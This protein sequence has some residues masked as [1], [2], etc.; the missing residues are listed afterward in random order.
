[1]GK[2]TRRRPSCLLAAKYGR[3]RQR[4]QLLRD[5][6]LDFFIR[7][8]AVFIEAGG[9]GIAEHFRTI[10]E[11]QVEKHADL[12]KVVLCPRSAHTAAGS[13]KCDNLQDRHT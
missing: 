13:L 9:E 12:G 8:I 11:M 10:D 5:R 4:L 1:M 3:L 6:F 2:A 7:Q